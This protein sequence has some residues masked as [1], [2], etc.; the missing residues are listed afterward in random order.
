ME[1]ILDGTPTDELTLRSVNE[2][3]QQ[4][5]EPIFRR[6]EDLCVLLASRTEME[7]FGNCEASSSMRN[8]ESSSPSRNRHSSHW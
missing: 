5:T 6:I 2:T 1:P 3:I 7:S 4:S 8:R